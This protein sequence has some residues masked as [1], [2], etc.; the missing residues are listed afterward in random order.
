MIA[1]AELRQVV[2]EDRAD[3]ARKAKL[4]IEEE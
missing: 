3:A 1:N 4:A 2:A